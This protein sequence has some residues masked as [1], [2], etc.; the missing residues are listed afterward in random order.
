MPAPNPSA[1]RLSSATVDRSVLP[2]GITLLV[3]SNPSSPSVAIAGS[4]AAGSVLESEDDA[5]LASLSADA[6]I[7]G[8]E[9]RSFLAFSQEL[10][11]V[12]ASLAFG[13]SVERAGLHGRALAENLDVLLRLAGDALR[14]PTFPDEEVERLR[15]QV[16]AGIA[17]VEDNPGALA[18][19]RFH[20]LMFGRGNPFGRA[21]EGYRHTV[22]GLTPQALRDFH[23]GS[24]SP[25]A[26]TLTVVGAVQPLAVRDLVERYLGDWQAP[27]D[28]MTPELWRA[29][30]ES[31]DAAERSDAATPLRED[32][33]LAG[34]T[35]TEFLLGWIG[36]RRA[37]PT[38]YATMIA[39]FILGQLGLGGRI[40][41]NVRDKQGLAYH[42]SSHVE[43]SLVRLPWSVQAGVN[44]SNVERAVASSL[45]EI[46]GLCDAPPSD[47][48]LRLT[49]QAMV[50]SLPL[51][52]ERNDGIAQML[53]TIERYDLGLDYLAEYPDL[54]N[55]V[56]ASDVQAATGA[57]LSS[58]GHTLVTAGPSLS[59]SS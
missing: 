34:K 46:R 17:Q 3:Y 35:Q 32:L 55:G 52:L 31:F 28:A 23:A 54:V 30:V 58:P 25:A 22:S 33:S 48:E 12:G 40:G 18:E 53:L 11:E 2:N 10:D 21:E 51:R 49:K 9:T 36:I 14:N 41:A 1:V 24:Y 29:V 19:R 6:L 26:L 45:D 37:D 7:R 56:T 44:P 39:N 50:G 47:E 27:A 15:G 16:L 38:Y 5:G 57:V 20:E 59:E 42:A 4:Y 8:T 43:A 13:A